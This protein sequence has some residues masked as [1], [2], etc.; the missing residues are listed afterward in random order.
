MR[1]SLAVLGLLGV[2]LTAIPK[3]GHG[4][5]PQKGQV[6]LASWYGKAHDGQKTA[7]GE[8]F[9]RSQLTPAHRTLPLGTKVKV[10]NL[11]TGQDVVVKIND[12]GP[13]G[14]NKRR[15]IDLSEAAAARIGVRPRGI[16][17][18]RVVVLWDA[19]QP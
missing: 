14:G 11:R 4:R 8:R 17:P 10:T 13:Y 9:S 12:R 7:S 1:T 2:L 3:D 6:G 19:S 5:T 15:I 16:E 18:M